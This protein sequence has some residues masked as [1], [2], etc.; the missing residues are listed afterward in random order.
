MT[1]L[2]KI[3]V[4]TLLSLLFFSCNFD[5]NFGGVV[6]N[7]NVV[8]ESRTINGS[9]NAIK[10]TEG[11]DVYVTQSDTE[12]IVVEADENLHELIITEVVDNVLKIHTKR[13]IGNATSKKIM[14]SFKNVSSITSTSGSNVYSKNTV[15]AEN[16]KLESSSGSNMTLDVDTSTLKCNTS[17]GSNMTL[18][19]N[20]KVLECHSSSGSNIK[21]TGETIK[22]TAEASSGSNIKAGDLIAESS[23]ANASSGSNITINTSKELIAKA[24][25]GGGINYYGNPE[26]VEKSDHVSGSIRKK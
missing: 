8:E 10:A 7:G 3:I 15:T 22:L 6:G 13:N 2:T 24:S 11:L 12:S 1:T 17:S 20:T 9:F 18:Q 23:R 16:L 19:L 4:T 26:K 14:V 25:S 5:I 21:L